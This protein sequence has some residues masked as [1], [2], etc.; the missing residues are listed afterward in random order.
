[1]VPTEILA[2]QHFETLTEYLGKQGL[3]VELLQA[4]S[5]KLNVGKF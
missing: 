5:K 4:V 2:Q 1:M 3:R